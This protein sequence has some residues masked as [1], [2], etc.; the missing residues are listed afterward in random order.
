MK[1]RTLLLE[2][3]LLELSGHGYG[4]YSA[5]EFEVSGLRDLSIVWLDKNIVTND[6]FR[7]QERQK[8]DALPL[9]STGAFDSL[10]ECLEDAFAF[11]EDPVKILAD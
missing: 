2:E 8:T 10:S 3:A 4:V 9:R 11:L 5:P 6:K 7:W 1:K